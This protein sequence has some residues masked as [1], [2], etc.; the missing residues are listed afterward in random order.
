MYTE[1]TKVNSQYISSVLFYMYVNRESQE[2]S[3]MFVFELLRSSL[4]A[5][6][7][8]LIKIKGVNGISL[9]NRNMV[10]L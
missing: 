8:K 1:K 9:Y 7:G 10:N 4:C 5:F 6:D 2:T 3:K